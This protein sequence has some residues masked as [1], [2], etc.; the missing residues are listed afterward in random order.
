MSQNLFSAAR[1]G[2]V[3]AIHLQCSFVRIMNDLLEPLMPQ[4]V[5]TLKSHFIFTI[6]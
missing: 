3:G 1:N 2:P 6:F 4:S 5:I